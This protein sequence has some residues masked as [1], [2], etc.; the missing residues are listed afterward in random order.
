M[1]KYKEFAYSGRVYDVALNDYRSEM[2]R[3]TFMGFYDELEDD[4]YDMTG[5]FPMTT[6]TIIYT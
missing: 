2:V 3:D 6:P 1:P 5:E 4:L